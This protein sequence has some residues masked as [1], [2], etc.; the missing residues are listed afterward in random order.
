RCSGLDAVRVIPPPADF[1]ARFHQAAESRNAALQYFIGQPQDFGGERTGPEPVHR[2][3]RLRQLR[4]FRDARERRRKLPEKKIRKLLSDAKGDFGGAA[5]ANFNS[6]AW[7]GHSAR[8]DI[9]YG[10][11]RPAMLECGK[12]PRCAVL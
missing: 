10:N 12:A 11:S 6:R 2:A 4:R 9:S 1:R 5:H 8:W 3:G 7:P